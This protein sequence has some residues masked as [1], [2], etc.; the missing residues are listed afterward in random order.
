MHVYRKKKKKKNTLEYIECIEWA[1][2]GK[3][4]QE[5][6]KNNF[7]S[8]SQSSKYALRGNLPNVPLFFPYET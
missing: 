2:K 5:N 4:K 7:L 8:L 3:A 6:T 1:Q